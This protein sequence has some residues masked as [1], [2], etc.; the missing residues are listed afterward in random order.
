M[1][2]PDTRA[3]EKRD[4]LDY[5]LR[6]AKQESI[7]A[8]RSADPRAAGPH[9]HMASRYSAQAMELLGERVRPAPPG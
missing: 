1:D 3:A 7:A 2:Q 8:I 9:E 5:V 6:R 4:E